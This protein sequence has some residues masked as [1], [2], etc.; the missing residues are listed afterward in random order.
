MFEATTIKV[1]GVNYPAAKI[2]QDL[3]EQELAVPVGD[4]HYSSK[5]SVAYRWLNLG[6]DNEQF[7]VHVNGEWQDAESID[8][9]FL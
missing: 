7:Q 9:D 4:G 2:R 3:L 6:Q 1:N 5:E 8:F